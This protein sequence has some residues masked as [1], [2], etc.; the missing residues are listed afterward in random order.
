M[1]HRQ[2]ILQVG[3]L[4][5]LLVLLIWGSVTEEPKGQSQADL[6]GYK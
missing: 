5:I 6:G 2:L 1:G 4:K 3:P